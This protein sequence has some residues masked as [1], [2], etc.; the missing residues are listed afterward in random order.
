M[1]R[2]SAFTLI[3]MLLVV[4]LIALLIAM[5]LPSIGR[6][7]ENSRRTVC[8]NNLRQLHL[9]YTTYGTDNLGRLPITGSNGGTGG[10][11]YWVETRLADQLKDHYLG[12]SIDV[13]YCPSAL[14]GGFM[15]YP[16][17]PAQPTAIW[18]WDTW[19]KLANHYAHRVTGYGSQCH[20]NPAMPAEYRV[21]RT[22]DDPGKVLFDDGNE[23][24]YNGTIGIWSWRVA[25]EDGRVG[26]EGAN[27]AYLGGDVRWTPFAQM[28]LRWL[29]S[30]WQVWW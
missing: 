2:R 18:W 27:L 5:L 8:A 1:R 17:L 26:P 25:H 9:G 12:G 13:Y 23:A 4:S 20:L 30:S 15:T 16:S 21:R 22:N 28:K 6:T 10:E 7:K 3:E 19:Q 29:N 24:G 11:G 14:V